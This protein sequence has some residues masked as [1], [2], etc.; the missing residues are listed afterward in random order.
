[1]SFSGPPRTASGARGILLSRDILRALRDSRGWSQE[2]LAARAGIGVDTIYRAEGGKRVRG[3]SARAIAAAVDVTVN[4]LLA[5]PT[6]PAA[7][8]DTVAADSENRAL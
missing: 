3:E 7:G 8:A 1:M 5:I 6:L 2:E 4:V